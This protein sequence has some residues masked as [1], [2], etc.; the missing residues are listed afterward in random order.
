MRWPRR[1]LHAS[2]GAVAEVGSSVVTFVMVLPLL[3]LFLCAALDFGRVITC[4][5]MLSDATYAACAYGTGKVSQ[6]A[7]L[8]IDA[9]A[10]RQAALDAAP[11]LAGS[12]FEVDVSCDRASEV[13]FTRRIY[14]P[15]SGSFA[16]RS[17]R[18]SSCEVTAHATFKGRYLTVVGWAVAAASGA[19]DGS[20]SL[21]A[22]ASGNAYEPEG[23][24]HA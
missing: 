24:D 12:G 14:S 19:A 3:S 1:S 16:S 2:G 7:A 22:S 15:E 5:M 13:G 8:P 10:A 6:G 17:V 4:Q 11:A 20:F 23:D 18:L 9:Q 21:E